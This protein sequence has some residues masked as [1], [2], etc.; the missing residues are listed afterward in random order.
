[1]SLCRSTCLLCAW[2]SGQV[3][4]RFRKI[5]HNLKYGLWSIKNKYKQIDTFIKGINQAQGL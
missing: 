3:F 2:R 5:T 4:I 1:M